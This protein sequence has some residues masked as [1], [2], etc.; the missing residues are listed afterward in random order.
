[1]SEFKIED[2]VPIPASYRTG[3]PETFPWRKL[4][5]GESFFIPSEWVDEKGEARKMT[6]KGAAKRAH[7]AFTRTGRKFSTRAVDGGIR[8]WRVS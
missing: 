1:M 3:R 5:I 4:E 7:D 6:S 8:I 2:A